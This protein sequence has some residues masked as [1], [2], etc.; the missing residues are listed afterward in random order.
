MTRK[1]RAGDTDEHVLERRAENQGPMGKTKTFM[2]DWG[3]AVYLVVAVALSLGYKYVTPSDEIKAIKTEQTTLKDA[4]DELKLVTKEQAG[5]IKSF[6]LLQC[7]NTGY[8]T[9]Q[10]RLVGIDCTGIRQ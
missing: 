7:F 5:D 9:G 2:Q 8:T 3:W 1:L 6:K 10:L 4:V